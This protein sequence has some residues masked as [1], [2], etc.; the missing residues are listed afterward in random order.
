MFVQEEFYQAEP[1]IVASV[2]TQ[3]SL[4]SDLRAWGDKVY[5]A[6]KSEMKQLHFWDT[7]KPRYWRELNH[8][9]RQ[10]VMESHMFLKEKRDGAIKGRTMAGGKKQRDYISKEEASSPTVAT[11]AVLL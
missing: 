1:D 5:T 6:V 4:N 3:T 10:T 11:E 2:M 8:T 7:F 9:Q